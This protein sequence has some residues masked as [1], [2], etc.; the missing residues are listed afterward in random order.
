MLVDGTGID[1]HVGVQSG[2]LDERFCCLYAR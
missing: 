2:A 1:V